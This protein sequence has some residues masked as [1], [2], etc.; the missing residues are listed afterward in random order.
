MGG[1]SVPIEWPSQ[2]VRSAHFPDTAAAPY[3]REAVGATSEHEVRWESHRL[4]EVPVTELMPLPEIERAAEGDDP[5]K[6][7]ERSAAA[8]LAR[9]QERTLDA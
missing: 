1:A 8:Y 4:R 6:E 2:R 5:V 3:R 7:A 9:Y